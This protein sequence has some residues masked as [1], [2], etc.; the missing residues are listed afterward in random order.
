MNMESTVYSEF[1]RLGGIKLPILLTVSCLISLPVNA[2][3]TLPPGSCAISL[4]GTG[5]S[6]K[7]FREVN[8]QGQSTVTKAYKFADELRRDSELLNLI[9]ETNRSGVDGSF[10]I[11]TFKA[12]LETLTMAMEDIIGYDLHQLLQSALP[13]SQKQ[14]LRSQYQG[15]AFVLIHNLKT[16]GVLVASRNENQNIGSFFQDGKDDGMPIS[17]VTVRTSNGIQ[18]IIIKTDNVIVTQSQQAMFL[19]DPH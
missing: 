19:V 4:L 12:D 13:E 5:V 17:V 18:E 9:F 10:K 16:A 7:V 1:L 2:L 6:G 14:K 15:N 8:A 3:T 11:P